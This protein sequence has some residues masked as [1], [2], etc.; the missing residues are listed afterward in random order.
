[1]Q[2]C[3]CRLGPRMSLTFNGESHCN[4]EERGQQFGAVYRFVGRLH[5][6]RIPF[7]IVVVV[8]RHVLLF[9]K[10]SL[11]GEQ[12][13]ALLLFLDLLP[14]IG[15]TNRH[16]AV[17]RLHALQSSVSRSNSNFGHVRRR[18]SGPKPFT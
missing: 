12:T 5:L 17:H 7:V 2:K 16:L 15:Q 1:M 8:V 6:Q 10:R 14:W 9:V 13:A 11:Q 3:W 4:G 18:T